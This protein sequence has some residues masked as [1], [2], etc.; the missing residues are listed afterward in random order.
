MSQGR[1]DHRRQDRR[2]RPTEITNMLD[3]DGVLI[4]SPGETGRN[5]NGTHDT[6]ASGTPGG[7]T[8]AGGLAGTNVGDAAPGNADIE[9][10]LGD[11]TLDEER[12]APGW[13]L[14]NDGDSAETEI[15]EIE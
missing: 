4:Q 9:D 10:A 15:E 6:H 2:G 11:P 8:S 13:P 7:G 12:D 3:E 1:N 5:H 14:A